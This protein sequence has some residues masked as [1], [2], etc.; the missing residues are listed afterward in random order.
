LFRLY[1]A[2]RRIQPDIVHLSTP[3]GALLGGLAAW[4]A[5]VK[6]RIFLVRGLTSAQ[7]T[8]I[9]RLLFQKLERLTARLATSTI[10]NA[11][12]LLAYAR[13]TGI[14][15]PQEGTVLLKG[16]SNGVDVARFNPEITIAAELAATSD[17]NRTSPIGG[18]Q[19]SETESTPPKTVVGFVGRLALDKGIEV[20]ADAWRI[21]RG[22]FPNTLLLLV[23]PWETRDTV[24]DEVRK[25]LVSDP[26]VIL[27]G[28]VE[29]VCPYY[30][31]IDVFVLPSLGEGFPNS[32][33][34]AAAF[35][36]PV[37]TTNSTGCCD[38]V[39]DGVTG[40]RVPPRDASALA[41]AIRT[42]LSDPALRSQHGSAGRRRV[43][44][45]FQQL[46][47]WKAFRDHYFTLLGNK[48]REPISPGIHES[49]MESTHVV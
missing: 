34:E 35:G 31:R 4:L 1:R 48:D 49:P 30:K 41:D 2:L 46:P 6:T 38:A 22:E 29:D 44:A 23:G 39:E 40:F 19:L 45:D 18:P 8:G 10:C 33:M 21:I 12:S 7:S 11:P 14:L 15:G 16:M 47:I 13:N 27:P 32:A 43:L 17:I 9:T 20:L 26:R 5:N 42:Y 28:G 25:F 3:K 37:I 36:L 24:S